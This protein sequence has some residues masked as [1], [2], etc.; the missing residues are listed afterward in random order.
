MYPL[1]LATIPSFVCF[2][3]TTENHSWFSKLASA[4]KGSFFD[5]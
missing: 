4:E 5:E 1:G 3:L 2:I